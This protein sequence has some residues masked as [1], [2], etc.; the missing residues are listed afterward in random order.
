MGC[1]C[2]K[3][4]DMNYKGGKPLQKSSILYMASQMK[5]TKSGHKIDQKIESKAKTRAEINKLAEV[6]PGDFKL[7]LT[8]PL[9]NF[10]QLKKYL[11]LTSV[12]GMTSENLTAHNITMII[13]ATY[14]WPLIQNE[15]IT[16][17]R[18]PVDDGVTEVISIYFDDVTDKINECH[19]SGGNCVVHCVAG[20][21]RST[22][23]VLAYLIKYE[24]MALRYAY[25]SVRKRRDSARPN[26]GFWSQLIDYEMMTRKKT[27][28][29]ILTEV[30]DGFQVLYPDVL[31][32][33][34]YPYYQR[35]I[36]QQLDV[37]KDPKLK[38]KSQKQ[39]DD[40][41]LKYI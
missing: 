12:G 33:L 17:Y 7:V 27:S 26:L 10:D 20:A 9:S 25:T 23:L 37:L 36:N 15:T 11:Y 1:L 21:S 3:Q 16:S 8:P 6:A 29:K 24:R 34:H 30:V 13:N 14:E 22:T 5:I 4:N 41:S 32:E 39:F 40:N 18:V 19:K 28:V 31:K 38:T 35:I 2:S